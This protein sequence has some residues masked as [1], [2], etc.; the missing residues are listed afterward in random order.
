[1]RQRLLQANRIGGVRAQAQEDLRLVQLFWRSQV[2][3]Q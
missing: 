2:R 1:M 3:T